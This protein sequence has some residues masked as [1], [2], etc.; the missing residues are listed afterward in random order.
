M[1]QASCTHSCMAVSYECYFSEKHEGKIWNRITCKIFGLKYRALCEE[2]AKKTMFAN[3]WEFRSARHVIQIEID[4]EQLCSAIVQTVRG[5]ACDGCSGRHSLMA[6]DFKFW[7]AENNE[8]KPIPSI[9]AHCLCIFRKR[10][11][12]LVHFSFQPYNSGR[13][14]WDLFYADVYPFI[15]WIT[16]VLQNLS[17]RYPL[18]RVTLNLAG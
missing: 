15:S 5:C 7:E 13:W 11:P 6:V 1:R 3:P 17:L 18:E 10:S 16:S 8:R 2:I 4:C 9:S 12:D 14:D